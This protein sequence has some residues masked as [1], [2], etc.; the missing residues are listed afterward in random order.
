MMMNNLKCTNVTILG[1]GKWLLL[2]MKKLVILSL[3]NV[4]FNP[5]P[6]NIINNHLL[7]VQTRI[8]VNHTNGVPKDESQ[9][10][11]LPIRKRMV[12]NIPYR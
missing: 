9:G 12:N 4:M 10:T 5:L 1:R 8:K 2:K 7:D 11:Q 3:K 6:I